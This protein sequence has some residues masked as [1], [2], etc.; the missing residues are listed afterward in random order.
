[1]PIVILCNTIVRRFIPQ[2]KERTERFL[3]KSS[4]TSRRV[5]FLRGHFLGPI[6]WGWDQTWF[7]KIIWGISRLNE[8]KF[9]LVSYDHW[10]FTVPRPKCHVSPKKEG[11]NVT[12][13]SQKW[14]WLVDWKCHVVN[15]VDNRQDHLY[16]LGRLCRSAG[17][18]GVFEGKR[19]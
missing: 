2:N 8:W 18:Q 3:P 17:S 10:N 14:P 13:F 12:N 1:M 16:G 11:P 15:D 9:G 5:I 4:W 6:L 7:Q 19:G